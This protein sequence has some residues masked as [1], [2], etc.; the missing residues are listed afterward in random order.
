[1][2]TFGS[3]SEIDTLTYGPMR[4]KDIATIQADR[5]DPTKALGR[6]LNRIAEGLPAAPIPRPFPNGS[7]ETVL[8]LNTM[9]QRMVDSPSWKQDFAVKVDDLRNHYEMWADI[10]SRQTGETYT[11]R[12]FNA[13]ATQGNGLILY[14][15]MYHARPR[16]YQLAPLLGKKIMP[17]VSDPQ[18][19]AY[20]S[21]HAFD[22]WMFS[23]ALKV[24]YPEFHAVFDRFAERISESRIIGGVHFP[25]D[26]EA[27]KIL[28][29]FAVQQGL[30]DIPE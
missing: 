29:V 19:P 7:T 16:P 10:A 25:S 17:T 23:T 9:I 5:D 2:M 11:W 1:M 26:I 15:K 24:R 28:G 21:G 22:A 12:W 30:V 18:T 8:E 14:T 27:G 3:H 4:Q 6:Y 13:M 20:P